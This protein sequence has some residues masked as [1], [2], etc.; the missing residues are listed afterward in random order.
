MMEL[1]TEMLLWFF[2]L[3]FILISKWVA[4]VCL[5]LGVTLTTRRGRQFWV[6]ID[7]GLSI[8]IGSGWADETPSCYYH[9]RGDWTER[10]ANLLFFWQ[11]DEKGQRNHCYRAWVSER[12]RRHMPPELRV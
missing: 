8:V 5:F 1:Y 9:R 7:Q 12:D 4:G 3:D 10:A 6:W 2:S 11:K